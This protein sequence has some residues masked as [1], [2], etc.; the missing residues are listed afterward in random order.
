MNMKEIKIITTL[1]ALVAGMTLVTSCV[2]DNKELGSVLTKDQIELQVTQDFATD[3]GG[4][5]VILKNN[6]PGTV[7]MW[8]YGTGRSTRMQDTIHF[9]FKGD[10]IIKR[11]VVTAGGIVDLDPVTISVTENN[12]S[13]VSGELWTLLTGGV[14]HEKTWVLDYGK[15][16]IFDGPLSYYEPQTTWT[17]M[18]NGTA[19]LGWAPAWADN[20]WIIPEADK[21][22][23][24]TFSL[25]GGPFLKTHKVTEGVDESGS[26]FLDITGR[27]LTTT[28]ATILRSASFIPNASNWNSNLVILSL[29]EDQLQVG[30][31]RTNNEG[32][33][34][35]VWN[36]ISKEYAD[37]YV[38]PVVPD[39]NF[40][41]KNQLDILAGTTSKTWRLDTQVPF[42]W[43]DLSGKMLNEKWVSRATIDSWTGFDDADVEGFDAFN[44]I[45]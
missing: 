36:Y 35:Y 5:T 23:T 44:H 3:P 25:I 7:S 37:N 32:D 33:Y 22:S 9:A 26:Y 2:D 28:D 15:H 11:S 24:M 16:G 14:G 41:F 18:H 34:L 20:Q 4:N 10:Y 13:Y 42:N 39:P 30:V 8:D 31:R 12:L 40:N 45:L 27:T 29:T 19:K 21:A 1:M 43:S 17:E 38:P 6:T